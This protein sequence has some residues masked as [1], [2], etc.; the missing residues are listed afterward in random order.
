MPRPVSSAAL[1]R[2]G[3]RF[4]FGGSLIAVAAKASRIAETPMPD[5][6]ATE[7]RPAAALRA[8]DRHRRLQRGTAASPNWSAA[9]EQLEIAGGHEIV[10][11]NDGSRD[12]SLAVCRGLVEQARAADHAARACRATTA[13]TTR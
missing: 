2:G 13:N 3:L 12:N 6:T 1:L 8:V 11:V 5:M 7:S 4:P 10:L 9:L